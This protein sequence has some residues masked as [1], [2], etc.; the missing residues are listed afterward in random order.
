MTA[1]ILV[2]ARADFLGAAR[3]TWFPAVVCFSALLVLSLTGTSLFGFGREVAMRAE[4]GF[5]TVVFSIL[6]LALFASE[7]VLRRG[8]GDLLFCRPGLARE[9]FASAFLAVLGVSALGGAMV[10]HAVVATLL[11]AGGQTALGCAGVLYLFV[12]LASTCRFLHRNEVTLPAVA[13][14]A[15]AALLPLTI[16][17]LSH[18]GGYLPIYLLSGLIFCIAEGILISIVC[19]GFQAFLPGL[20]GAMLAFLAFLAGSMKGFLVAQKLPAIAQWPASVGLLFLPDFQ[21]FHP[22]ERMGPLFS[23]PVAGKAAIYVLL[24]TTG[25]LVLLT[26]MTAFR[27]KTD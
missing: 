22:A 1:N 6:L 15:A 8:G 14:G 9:R 26:V 20:G 10:V 12:W 13:L 24:F 2:L 11:I 21:A 17:L 16:A 19:T 18:S 27:Q 4:M 7:S 25:A 5:S 3:K 23:W